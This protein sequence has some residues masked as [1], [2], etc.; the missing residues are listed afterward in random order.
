[1]IWGAVWESFKELFAMSE[2]YDHAKHG[3]IRILYRSP[4]MDPKK[5]GFDTTFETLSFKEAME[6]QA[7]LL[8][9][10]K[11]FKTEF[12]KSNRRRAQHEPEV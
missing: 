6:F 3:W 2:S 4:T 5:D 9:Q 7:A 10:G 8:H 1:M 11:E 12:P